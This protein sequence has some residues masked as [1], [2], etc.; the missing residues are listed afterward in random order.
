MSAE[1]SISVEKGGAEGSNE[2]VVQNL[3]QQH[4]TTTPTP[5]VPCILA[6]VTRETAILC[7]GAPQQVY[8]SVWEVRPSVGLALFV[9]KTT[10]KKNVRHCHFYTVVCIVFS[11]YT[12]LFCSMY[13]LRREE[14]PG[15]SPGIYQ[16]CSL[17]RPLTFPFFH[18]AWCV[19][20]SKT[21]LTSSVAVLAVSRC[22]VFI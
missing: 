15:F 21:V 16:M 13:Q 4:I 1:Q 22:F 6:S 11:V 14:K 17:N 19:L 20:I 12:C 2:V 5:S 10:R 9:E 18:P 7:V 3:H 8:E